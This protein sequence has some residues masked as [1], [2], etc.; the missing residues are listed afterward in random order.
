MSGLDF[1]KR[2]AVRTSGLTKQFGKTRLAVDN[3][4]L[5]IKKGEIFSLLGPN[6]AGKTTTIKMLC[7]LLRPTSGTAQI[8]G[9]DILRSPKQ[10]KQIINVSPQET[11][12]APHLSVLE[13]LVLVGEI[14][15]LSGREAKRRAYKLVEMMDL[16]ERL[17]ERANK[18]SGG[19]LRRL[20]IAMALIS[21]PK[22]LFLDEPTLGL[23]PKSRKELWSLIRY[24]R[25]RKRSF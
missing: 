13:N 21:D 25:G 16:S 24:L 19:L 9:L 15:G 14:Y 3:L 7:C 10:I 12:V 1:D 23:D 2:L 17:R 5:N 6:G 22:V 20:S 8:M 4:D 18:L 11:A